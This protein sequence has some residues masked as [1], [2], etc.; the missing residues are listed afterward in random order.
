VAWVAGPVLAWAV[1]GGRRRG[2]VAAVALGACD[3]SIR[4]RI[5]QRT[6]GGT[7][8]LLLAALA[9]GHVARLAV[10][11]QQRH[12]RAVELEAANRSAAASTTSA[13]PSPSRRRP[14]QGTEVELTVPRTG[15][16]GSL[17]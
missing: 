17:P 5:D 13:A 1:S 2:A 3:L 16:P 9:V 14:N 15:G 10:E 6:V 7:V 12:Q 4:G 8:L 11:A